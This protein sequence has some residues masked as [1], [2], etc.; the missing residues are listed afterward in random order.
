MV[1]GDGLTWKLLQDKG[2]RFSF[3]KK[4]REKEYLDRQLYLDSI[5]IVLVI[6]I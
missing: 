5:N 6:G 2:K 3:R 4:R 1:V